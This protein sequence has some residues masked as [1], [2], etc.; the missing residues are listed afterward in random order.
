MCEWWKRIL[1]KPSDKNKVGTWL[2]SIIISERKMLLHDVLVLPTLQPHRGVALH[3]TSRKWHRVARCLL[4][5][6]AKA[7]R[8]K[9]RHHQR[10]RWLKYH[11]VIPFEQ[12]RMG[13]EFSMI[14]FSSTNRQQF[15]D[16]STYPA[17]PLRPHKMR[18][19]SRWTRRN[20]ELLLHPHRLSQ[21]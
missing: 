14:L 11:A 12:S 13:I 3:V 7:P 4:L 21:F 5:I 16:S 15:V 9:R 6:N 20:A 1:N 19:F 10:L 8:S 17:C 18:F 2:K